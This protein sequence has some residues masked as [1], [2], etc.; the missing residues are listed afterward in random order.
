MTYCARVRHIVAFAFVVL[1]A[2]APASAQQEMSRETKVLNIGP[3]AEIRF[4]PPWAPSAVKYGNAQE[5]VVMQHAVPAVE[6]KGAEQPT[7][8]AVA[9][10]LITTEL[11]GSYE[12][13]LQRL[14]AIA[15]SRDDPAQ[16]VEIGG[17]PSVEVKFVEPLPRRGARDEEDPNHF[18]QRSKCI[19]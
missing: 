11:R 6:K 16:F 10:V 3:Q 18:L 17:W 12:N 7:G 15:A 4:A 9:R 5:L 19:A 14:R 2:P 13:A 1:I 8:Y